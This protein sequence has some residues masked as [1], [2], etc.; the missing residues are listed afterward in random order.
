[1]GKHKKRW[2]LAKR[3]GNM[4]ST[5][6]L[7]RYINSRQWCSHKQWVTLGDKEH[8]EFQVFLKSMGARIDP[9]VDI[10]IDLNGGYNRN[11][12]YP[13]MQYFRDIRPLILTW[14]ISDGDVCPTLPKAVMNMLADG[15]T[16]GWG[17]LGGHGRTGWLAAKIH[18]MITG[19]SGATAIGYIR[20]VYCEEAIETNGQI[21]DLGGSVSI[22]TKYGTVTAGGGATTTASSV[23]GKVSI[24][25]IPDDKCSGHCDIC[26]QTQCEFHEWRDNIA[27]TIPPKEQINPKCLLDYDCANCQYLQNEDGKI[28]CYFGDMAE[29]VKAW[30]VKVHQWCDL[31]ED[32]QDCVEYNPKKQGISKCMLG[33]K[34]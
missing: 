3:G 9:K 34:E 22:K 19:C 20:K 15:K 2:T 1:M 8:G 7:S 13:L 30:R 33:D 23:P 27:V 4:S 32:C 28:S 26:D 12:P 18:Q 21:L 11:V 5:T 31:Y 10:F 14:E 25:N 16:L 6:T 29:R 24:D 17:C